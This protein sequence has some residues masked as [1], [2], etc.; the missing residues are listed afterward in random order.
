MKVFLKFLKLLIIVGFTGFTLGVLAT[1]AAYF[2]VAPGLPSIETLKDVRLQVPLR[3]YSRDGA[4]IAEFGEKRRSPLKYSETP[5]LMIKA[6][7][8]AEDDRFFEHPGVD[9]QGILRAVLHLLR[10]GEKGPGG[11]TI[12]MQVA[13]NFFLTLDKT[14]LRKIS[15]IFLALRIEREFSK[16]EILELYLNKIYLGHRA[17]GV[18]A[19]A[20]VY[21]GK[22]ADQLSLAQM[23]MIAGLPKAPSTNNPVVNLKRAMIRRNYVLGRMRDLDFIDEATYLLAS[24]EIDDAQVH[25]L[26]IELEAPHVAEMVRASLLERFG[27]DVYTSG[28]RVY[29]S[30]EAAPQR[31]AIQ[32]VRKGLIEYD[33]RH[34]YRGPEARLPA[35]DA[36]GEAD[37]A[38]WREALRDIPAVGGL[39]PAVVAVVEEQGATL[40]LGSG[41][42]PLLSWDGLSWAKPY[43][44]ERKVG[45]RPKRADEILAPG[46]LVRLLQR[47]DGSWRLAQIPAV[48][49]ALVSLRPEDGG[50]KALVGGFDF[51]HSKFN[52]VT[53]A[54][55]QPGSNF[56]P[57]I[58]SAALENGFTAATTINDAPVVFDDPS[59]ESAWR[60]ENYSGKFYGPTRLREALIKSRNLVSIRLLR[61]IGVSKAIEHASVF[62]FDAGNLPRNLSLALGSG[63]LTPLELVRAYGVF[64]NG[65][66]LTEPYYIVRVVDD[67]DQII[68]RTEPLLVCRECE[69]QEARRQAAGVPGTDSERQP[70][71]EFTEAPNTVDPSQSRE[72]RLSDGEPVPS[73][74]PASGAEGV[75]D[76]S[77]PAVAQAATP[78]L[79]RAP[80]VVS[81]QN[82]Y[83][84]NSIMRDVIRSGT[85]RR[86]LALGRRDLAGKTGTTN[87]Q[88]DA[89]F[90][91]FSSDQV[92]TAWIG[93]DNGKP[94]GDG[95]T[96]SRAALPMWVEYM[97]QVLPGVPE[98]VMEQP[99]GLV[100]VRI[101][102]ETGEPAGIGSEDAMFE[103]FRVEHAP[104]QTENGAGDA[105]TPLKKSNEISER[106]F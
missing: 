30:I 44:S 80:R 32:A 96:G 103:M 20:Q 82:V 33:T 41:E 45:A 95:E 79:R 2:Y 54:Q 37:L 53:Q 74:G 94:L 42:A 70:G 58:Y 57:F 64:A 31:A 84:M 101:D 106:L 19:A 47:E 59:L 89:W 34:G 102:R 81:E 50:I 29:T 63:A 104:R 11:S 40:L 77:Q 4:L 71:T 39:K 52:R 85:A 68:M 51:Y 9:Y 13:R 99:P 43:I 75:P 105:H 100:T 17:Y 27:P 98:R 48:E 15:E 93:F 25:A 73:G 62:G 35:S 69:L 28:Y 55:R 72:A 12:T 23:A 88:R 90:S 36:G 3:V 92:V 86:A 76:A 6:V 7:L 87:D 24:K 38:A 83:I 14:Y 65:G 67:R 91:G 46:D 78:A 56:K 5:E 10:T 16:R 49:G 8:A 61:A 18:A 26:A 1:A 21:Y 97:K 60:P 66:Y 22:T